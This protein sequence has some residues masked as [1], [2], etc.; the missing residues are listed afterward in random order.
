ME[1]EMS[2]DYSPL[3]KRLIDLKMTKTE[4]RLKIG[5]STS[6]LSKMNKGEPVS[7]SIIEKICSKLDLNIEEVIEIKN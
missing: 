2:I 5:I 6:A 1:D 3:W 7:L 4:L